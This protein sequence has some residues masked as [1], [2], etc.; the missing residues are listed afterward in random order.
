MFDFEALLIG[1]GVGLSSAIVGA[2]IDYRIS[3]KR[4][5]EESENGRLPGCIFLVSGSLGFLGII[6]IVL[7]FIAESVGRAF[8]AGLGVGFGFFFG[9][10]FMM[11]M[12]FLT[13]RIKP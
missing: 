2:I 11:G 6:V 1:T 3:K 13:Q 5:K 7:S 8:T 10:V 4:N 9:F 12:W